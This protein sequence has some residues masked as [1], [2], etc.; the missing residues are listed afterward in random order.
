MCNAHCKCTYSMT[1]SVGIGG[2]RGAAPL[3]KYRGAV[4]LLPPLNKYRGAIY[5]LPPP[6]IFTYMYILIYPHLYII[7][8][9]I[10]FTYPTLLYTLYY[11]DYYYDYYNIL[12][13]LF[14][15]FIFIRW[16]HFIPSRNLDDVFQL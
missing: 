1:R 2:A 4:Y 8:T 9:Y 15:I 14:V 12:L 5:I 11:Y 16:S 13:L 3:N 7:Y 6:P 10:F